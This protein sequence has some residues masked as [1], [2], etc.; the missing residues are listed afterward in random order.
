MRC[1]DVAVLEHVANWPNR[2]EKA[3]EAFAREIRSGGESEL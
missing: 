3:C 2:A 1:S